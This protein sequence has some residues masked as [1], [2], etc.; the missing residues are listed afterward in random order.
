MSDSS[1]CDITTENAEEL[2][3]FYQSVMGWKKEAID[4]GGYNDYVMMKSDGTPIGGICHKR[5]VNAQYPGGWI[6]YFTVDTLEAA[7][8]AVV[9]KGGKQ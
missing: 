2:V 4:M 7:L 5:G 9:E 3:N 8:K 1:W 6:N